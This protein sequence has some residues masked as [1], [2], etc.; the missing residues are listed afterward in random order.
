MLICR[1]E[2]AKPDL[3]VKLIEGVGIWKRKSGS[4]ERP[5]RKK[6]QAE[7][8]AEEAAIAPQRGRNG[9][10]GSQISPRNKEGWAGGRETFSA[11]RKPRRDPRF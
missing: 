4:F 6:N 1:V 5:G 10:H 11:G 9:Q 2:V 7:E 8:E 3:P